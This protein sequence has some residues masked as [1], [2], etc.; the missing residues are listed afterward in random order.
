MG[1]TCLVG[2]VRL[3]RPGLCEMRQVDRARE[4]MHIGV[5]RTLR[6]VDGLATREDDIRDAEEFFLSLDKLWRRSTKC[7]EFVHA[8]VNG[9]AR[10]QVRG[11]AKCH[12]R[13]KPAIETLKTAVGQEPIE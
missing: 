7:R 12:W 13:V 9:H 5:L 8:V 4:G 2:R 6:L 10:M 1:N 3:N 11:E